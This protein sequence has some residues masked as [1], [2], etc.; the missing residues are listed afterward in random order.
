VSGIAETRVEEAA[1]AWLGELGYDVANGLAIGPDGS[2][3]ERTSYGDI[4]LADRLKTAIARLNPHLNAETREDVFRKVLQSET[5]SLTEENRRLHR[6]VVEGVPVEITRADGTIG[7]DSA[8][9]IDFGN[10]DANDWLA[11]NQFTIIENKANRRRDIIIF[12][13][14]LPVGVIELKNPGD[15]N[16]TLDGAFNQLQTYKAQ[17]TSTF[18][19]NAALVISDGIAARIGSLTADRERSWRTLTGDD[20][21]PKGVPEL[22][23]LLKGAFD[24]RRLLDLIKDFV[25]FGQNQRQAASDRQDSRRLSPVPRRPP[26]RYSHH[27]GHPP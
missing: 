6:F 10:L 9:L 8:R 4:V 1:L 22:E 23:T 3:P 18:R 17:I 21:A 14:G 25:V 13:N 2:A 20:I 16:A 7:G 5:P 26:R 27:R 24:K 19:T 15:E 11:V 12:L